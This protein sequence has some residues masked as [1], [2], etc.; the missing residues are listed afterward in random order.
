[1]LLGVLS[2]IVV[3]AT[4]VVGL[5][6]G[7]TART[8]GLSASIIAHVLWLYLVLYVLPTYRIL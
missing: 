3:L 4:W 7:F 2:I 5:V 8:Q 1:M 6:L